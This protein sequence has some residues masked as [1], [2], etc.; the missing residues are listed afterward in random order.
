MNPL[1]YRTKNLRNHCAFTLVELLV[2]IAILGIL[3][4]MLLPAVQTV[5]E[6]ARRTVCLNHLRQIGLALQNHHSAHRE[7]PVGGTGF[8]SPWSPNET[9]IAWSAFLLPQLEQNTIFRSLD[10]T[11]AFDHEANSDASAN[12]IDVFIC[13]SSERGTE[14]SKGRGPCDYG[15]M[16]GERISGPNN[17]PK[18]LMIYGEAF[19]H[20]DIKDGSSNTIIVAE[21][22]DFSDGQWINGRNIFDQAFPINAAP[23]FENDIRSRHPQGANVSLADGSTHFINQAISL[24]PLAAIC[25]RAGGEVTN[26]PF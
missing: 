25:T 21:D 15:G 17:P 10:F 23:A 8:R 26:Y 5:R 3:I 19:S 11:H 16:F 18:G 12:V 2:V 14:L 20:R 9:Q 1:R 6:S 22:S 4:G 24:E 13:P 7:F